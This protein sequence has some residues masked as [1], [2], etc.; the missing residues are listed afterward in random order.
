LTSSGSITGTNLTLS[1]NLTVNGTTTTIDTTNLLIEDN[2]VVLNKNQT[3]TPSSSLDSG[4][5]VERGNSTNAKLY[6]D[7]ATDRWK[8]NL[9]GTVKTL[10]FAEDL[11][12]A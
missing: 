11:Y 10:A 7:E 12:S 9:G 2:M 8:V 6:W 1:G 3:G 5:E 4:I